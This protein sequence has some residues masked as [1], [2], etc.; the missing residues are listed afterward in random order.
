MPYRKISQAAQITE[1]VEIRLGQ[2]RK[3][4]S[5]VEN[6]TVQ[7]SRHSCSSFIHRAKMG[8]ASP[9]FAL[10]FVSSLLTTQVFTTQV[11]TTQDSIK[12]LDTC[13]HVAD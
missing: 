11:S 12:N 3:Q 13:I 4:Y 1:C 7:D 9:I 6:C 2:V 10:Q 8:E 5:N